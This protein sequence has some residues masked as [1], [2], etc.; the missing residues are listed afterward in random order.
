MVKKARKKQ[1]LKYI[2]SVG[3]LRAAFERVGIKKTGKF[4]KEMEAVVERFPIVLSSYLFKKSLLSKAIY[5]QFIPDIAEVEDVLGAEDPLNEDSRKAT[6]KLIHMYPDRA[7]LLVTDICFS[8]CRFCTRKRIK[9]ENEKISKKELNDA[10]KYLK[11]NKQIKDV[12]IS[13]GDPLTLSDSDLEDI[14]KSLKK[15]PSIKY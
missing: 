7:L 13:G 12:I 5:K 8:S 6:E 1:S 4:Y 10:C 14:I 15:I 11:K 2:S 3:D 9:M